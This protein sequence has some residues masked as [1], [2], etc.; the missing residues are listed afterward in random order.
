MGCFVKPY[1]CLDGLVA[2][3]TINYVYLIP[4]GIIF[5]MIYNMTKVILIWKINMQGVIGNINAEIGKSLVA[6]HAFSGC[7]TTSV[8]CENRIDRTINSKILAK[9]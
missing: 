3:E 9:N 6:L 1:V 8:F 5:T 7:D 2:M 4:R